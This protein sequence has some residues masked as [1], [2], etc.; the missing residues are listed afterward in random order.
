VFIPSEQV[1]CDDDNPA[2]SPQNAICSIIK[3][4]ITTPKTVCAY[5]A[6][7]ASSFGSDFYR[8]AQEQEIATFTETGEWNTQSEGKAFNEKPLQVTG[9]E[10]IKTHIDQIIA[11][12]KRKGK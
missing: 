9:I 7:W 4:I 1:I 6:D 10:D 8:H 5:P 11:D 2:D 3:P 12:I